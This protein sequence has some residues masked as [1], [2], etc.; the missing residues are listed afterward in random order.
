MATRLKTLRPLFPRSPDGRLTCLNPGRCDEGWDRG[1]TA[2]DK[3]SLFDLWTRKNQNQNI[4][5]ACWLA[6]CQNQ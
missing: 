2:V 6:I 3:R 5:I 1:S 4:L